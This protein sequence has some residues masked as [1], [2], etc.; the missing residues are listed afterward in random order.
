METPLKRESLF[1]VMMMVITHSHSLPALY[2]RFGTFG[3]F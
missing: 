1:L 2:F 3:T